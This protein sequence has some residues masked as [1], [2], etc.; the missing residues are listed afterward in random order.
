MSFS[1]ATVVL[2]CCLSF[3]PAPATAQ[4]EQAAFPHALLARRT[5]DRHVVPGYRKL[6][7]ASRS[8][9]QAIERWCRSN[10]AESSTIEQR[11]DGAVAAWGEIEQIAFGP[12]TANQLRDRILYYPDR[13]GLAHRQ[14]AAAIASLASGGPNR[15]NASVAFD[16]LSAIDDLLFSD[17]KPRS[18]TAADGKARCQVA[19]VAAVRLADIS[20]KLLDEWT[21]SDGYA[22]DWLTAGEP[23]SLLLDRR[24]TT[25]ALARTFDSGMERLREERIVAPLGFSRL[26]TMVDPPLAAS[27][28]TMLLLASNCRGMKHLYEEGGLWQAI[29]QAVPTPRRIDVKKQSATIGTILSSCEKTAGNL[30]RSTSPYQDEA[31]RKALVEI[32]FPLKVARQ[33]VE[34]LLAEFGEATLG[35]NASDGD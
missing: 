8:L 2:G 24:E 6:A 11:F 23:G 28:R 13:K 31:S 16:G 4:D 29:D 1:R 21:A 27:R 12:I 17:G 33:R 5:L 25:R 3:L 30:I 22:R 7:D 26:R 9:Q 19:E 14:R 34:Q 10:S 35:F 20:G 18:L 15:I 32:G